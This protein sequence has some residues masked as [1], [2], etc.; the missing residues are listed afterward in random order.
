VV[1]SRLPV[2]FFLLLFLPVFFSSSFLFIFFSLFLFLF[3]QF[4]RR[5]PDLYWKIREEPQIPR[6]MIGVRGGLMEEQW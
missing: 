5:G 3:V 4:S 2:F 1:G 6:V